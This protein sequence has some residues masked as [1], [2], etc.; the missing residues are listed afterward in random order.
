MKQLVLKVEATYNAEAIRDHHAG[1]ILEHH[2]LS[3]HVSR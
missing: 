3:E 1:C 2:H